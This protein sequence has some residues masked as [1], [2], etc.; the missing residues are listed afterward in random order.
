MRP[1]SLGGTGTDSL[2]PALVRWLPVSDLGRVV[3][4]SVDAL[5]PIFAGPSVVA[6][7][8][9]AFAFFLPDRRLREEAA[10]TRPE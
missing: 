1:R 3:H 7:A 2:T 10:R 6:L 9:L 4:S 8:A 5:L